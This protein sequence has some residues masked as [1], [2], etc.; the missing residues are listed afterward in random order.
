MKGSL[1][2]GRGREGTEVSGKERHH[3]WPIRNFTE[4]RIQRYLPAH[5]GT[6]LLWGPDATNWRGILWLPPKEE[7]KF[8]VNTWLLFFFF[9][10]SKWNA[11]TLS[12]RHTSFS[13]QKPVST[14]RKFLSKILGGFYFIDSVFLFYH[15]SL[16][17]YLAVPNLSGTREQ[18][19]G[20]QFFHWLEEGIFPEIQVYYIYFAYDFYYY[21]RSTS[22]HQTL[23]PRD[24]GSLL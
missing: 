19:H 23:E 15:P 13:L 24:W 18:F 21:I 14:F 8:F 11:L 22:Y 9:T 12:N 1:V 17:L 20:R 5:P 4:C 3:R 6:S 10:P 16:V 2:G 7:N